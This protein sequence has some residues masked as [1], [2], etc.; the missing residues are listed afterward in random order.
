MVIKSARRQVNTEGILHVSGQTI[1]RVF[2]V[3]YL[4]LSFDHDLKWKSQVQKVTNTIA[5]LVGIISKIRHYVPRYIL[6]LMY[7]TLILPH[8][9]YCIEIWGNTYPS[10]LEPILLL[11]KKI[12]RF[13]TFS[14]FHAPSAPLF[15]HLRILDVYNLCK[16]HTCIFIFDLLNDRFAHDINQ[17]LDQI[18]HSY[19]T[20]FATHGNFHVPKVNLTQNK[21]SI[22]YAATSHW[23]S[24]PS[25]IKNIT[26]RHLFKQTLKTYLLDG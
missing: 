4:G 26:N 21:Y 10:H 9:N 7:N 11:Q 22:K 6:L 1:E 20:R 14:D 17:Y 3:T 25:H 13:I 2:S 24:L 8:V 16:F 19:P 5:P 12:V 15:Q 23:N 18:P